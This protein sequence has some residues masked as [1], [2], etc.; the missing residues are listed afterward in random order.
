MRGSRCPGGRAGTPVQRHTLPGRW[1]ASDIPPGSPFSAPSNSK[2][3]SSFPK[4]VWRALDLFSGS[5]SVARVLRKLGWEVV[6]LDKASRVR[7]DIPSDIMQWKFWE[8]PKGY[9]QLIAASPHCQRILTSKNSGSARFEG[10]GS[11]CETNFGHH[12]AF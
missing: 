2:L 3:N 4:G 8:V 5:G 12:C 10:G 7:A 11:T 1:G 6:T 9:F